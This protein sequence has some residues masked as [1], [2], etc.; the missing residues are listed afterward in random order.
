[1]FQT[2][3]TL[4]RGQAARQDEAL[5]DRYAIELIDQK[6]REAEAQQKAAKATL[7][8]LIQRERS[9]QRQLE[10]LET[11]VADLTARAREALAADRE[12]LAAEAAAAIAVQEDEV[13]LR[14]D[15]LRSM[16][17]R[18]LRLRQSV[19][20]GHRRLIDLRQGAQAARVLRREQDMQI[21]LR[22]T[23]GS[24]APVDEAEALIARVLRRD[25]PAEQA[26]ILRELERDLNHEDLPDRLAEAGFGTPSKTRAAD[27][28]ARLK[29]DP[30]A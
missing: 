13:T 29:S 26:D 8:T 5:K 2:L 19:E 7:A 15:T 21:R 27:V 3:T 23:V 14:R 4:L 12:D 10:Q 30:K 18:V 22:T 17:T 6:I 25:D 24:A 16:E 28:L 9:E 11:R 1:M 20:A